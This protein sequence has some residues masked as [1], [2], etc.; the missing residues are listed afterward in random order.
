VQP[1]STEDWLLGKAAR[2]AGSAP[3]ALGTP[4]PGTHLSAVV[5][6]IASDRVPLPPPPGRARLQLAGVLTQIGC[7]ACLLV[8]AIGIVLAPQTTAGRLA[9][10]C[11]WLVL[12]M[13]GLVFGG[14]ICRGGLGKLI[15]AAAIDAGFGGALLALDGATLRAR[16]E[17]LPAS[18]LGAIARAL[19]GVGGA[20]LATAVL[21]LAVA[22]HG[23]R[24]AR[25]FRDA[26]ATHTALPLPRGSAY[27]IPAEHRPA[28]RRRLYIVLGGLAIGAG[29]G[30]GVV[31]SPA[32]PPGS[33]ARPELLGAAASAV[34][35]VDGGAPQVL[36]GDAGTAVAIESA[37]PVEPTPA[38]APAPA[39]IASVKQ[40]LAAQ[41]AAI[42][43]AD[44]QQLAEL[45]APAVFGFGAL[46]DEVAEGRAAVVA[47]IVRD[48]G[49]VPGR[50]TVESTS[51]AIGEQ[52]D[53]AWIAEQLDI[54]APGTVPRHVAM[55]ELAAAIDGRWQI[56]A[57]HWAT[58]IDDAVAEQ[59]AIVGGLPAPAEIADRH[60]D[61]ALD[62]AIRAAFASRAAFV[63]ARSARGD[64]FNLGSGGERAKG[65]AA[66]KRLFG[67]LNAQIQL[68]DGARVVAGS[69]WDPAQR[70][71]PWI[72]WA[73]VNVDFASQTRGGIELD[74][75]FRV[76]AIAIREGRAWKLVQT[77][78][79]SVAPAR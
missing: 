22:P 67:K 78:W 47:Q 59:L 45:M 24:Y 55:S 25:W 60:D 5:D 28:S 79:S 12:A 2:S 26:A 4:A 27:I 3:P 62:R 20:L 8:G 10:V 1:Q 35:T 73:A 58:P 70:G 39:P 54:A 31:V 48:L 68:H 49:P 21:C 14:L 69:A 57:L 74:Q 46:A 9:P 7:G 30:F 13:T 50:F 17:I 40:L 6:V 53:H 33:R 11:A 72:G 56:I 16:L 38:A 29:T 51:L 36:A 42:A 32:G 64:A 34:A 66:I 61:D 52:R 15:V 76:L 75:T 23:R 63:A 44:R 18:Q 71:D 77:Q 37:L 19:G 41:H 65:G 43:A